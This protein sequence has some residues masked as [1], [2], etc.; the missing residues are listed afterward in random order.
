M[1]YLMAA[2]IGMGFILKSALKAG[3]GALH[4]A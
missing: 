2:L 4:R 1:F 3:M